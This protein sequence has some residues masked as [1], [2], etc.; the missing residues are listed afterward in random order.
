MVSHC[1]KNEKE[2]WLDSTE[3]GLLS[4][5]QSPKQDETTRVGSACV[6][7]WQHF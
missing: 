7:K 5:C 2:A 4:A 1:A 3:D 6:G